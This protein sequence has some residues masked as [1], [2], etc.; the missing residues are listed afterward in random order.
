MYKMIFHRKLTYIL[1]K[2]QYHCTVDLLFHSTIQVNLYLIPK[3]LNP[4]QL[5]RRSA[6]IIYPLRFVYTT[7]KTQHFRL[8]IGHFISNENFFRFI[9]PA[10]L[11][12]NAAFLSQCKR[13][14]RQDGWIIIQYIDISNDE[15]FA[16]NIKFGQSGFNMF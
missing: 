10:S 14:F 16:K 13:T 1:C 9:K 8:S 12:Q 2:G 11:M 6:V 7:T 5:N 15:K 4:N 3:Q